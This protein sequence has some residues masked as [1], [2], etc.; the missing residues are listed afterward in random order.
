MGY[1][2]SAVEHTNGGQLV[3]SHLTNVP[4]VIKAWGKF[5][6]DCSIDYPI[7]SLPISTQQKAKGT[8]CFYSTHC[9][10]LGPSML[11]FSSTNLPSKPLVR[12]LSDVPELPL[13]PDPRAP[14]NT[15]LA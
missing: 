4:L 10:E 13:V 9:L 11:L 14:P 12:A 2:E 8:G 6:I 5:G 7:C 3:W 15:D 1:L